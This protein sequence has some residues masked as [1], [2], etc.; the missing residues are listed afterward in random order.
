MIPPESGSARFHLRLQCHGDDPC[1]G[2]F[3]ITPGQLRTLL[4]RLQRT[5]RYAYV[6]DHEDSEPVAV[7]ATA[8][9]LL[10]A[11]DR[12][13]RQPGWT[14]LHQALELYPELPL[15]G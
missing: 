6:L 4:E 1:L 10:S 11:L 5:F 8:D 9:A 7:Q 14:P 2:A 13:R 15:C 3:L 12:F